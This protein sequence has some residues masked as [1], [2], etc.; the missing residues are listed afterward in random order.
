MLP[1]QATLDTYGGALDNYRP[2]TD[3]TTDRDASMMNEAL[4]DV[5][6]MTRTNWRAWCRVTVNTTTG[7]MA[8]VAHRAQWG[9]APAV[10]PT[11]TRSSQGQF[12][13]TWPATVTDELGGSK[14][15]A[16]VGA[17]CNVRTSNNVHANISAVSTNTVSIAVW[18]VTT[19]LRDD[20]PY[21]VDV[22]VL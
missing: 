21:D 5:A 17:A 20:G 6:M 4:G 14:T 13:L 18:N 11:P 1:D 22:W 16:F 7:G 3:P 8:I 2:V 12:V 15:L 10:I 19:G 9:S